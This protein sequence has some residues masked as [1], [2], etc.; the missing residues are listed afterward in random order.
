MLTA[1]QKFQLYLEIIRSG[2][3]WLSVLIQAAQLLGS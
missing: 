2:P 1:E 3:A